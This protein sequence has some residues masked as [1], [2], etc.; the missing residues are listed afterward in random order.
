MNINDVD[1]IVRELKNL[2]LI[3]PNRKVIADSKIYC[4]SGALFSIKFDPIAVSFMSEGGL[5]WLLLHEEAHLIFPQKRYIAQILRMGLKLAVYLILV[6]LS[7]IF[8]ANIIPKNLNLICFMVILI[9]G[10]LTIFCFGT[11]MEYHI[12]YPLFS[13]RINKPYWDDEFKC[14]EYGI[15]GLL[16]VRPNLIAWQEAYSALESFKKCVKKRGRQGPIKRKIGQTQSYPHPPHGIRARHMKKLYNEFK[17]RK[18][19]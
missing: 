2:H 8:V 5:I 7:M 6:I 9:I 3:E 19:L 12:F 10:V 15:M 11:Y 4:N 16:L 13:S 18:N 14:D 1:K 17:K